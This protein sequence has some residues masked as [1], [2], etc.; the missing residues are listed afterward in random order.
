[1]I[2]TDIA[3]ELRRYTGKGTIKAAEVAG[4]LGDKNVSRVKG[5]YLRGLEAIGGTAYLITD[6]AERLKE[7]CELK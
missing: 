2:R 4:F 6:V 3:K 5:K 7:H 1:M